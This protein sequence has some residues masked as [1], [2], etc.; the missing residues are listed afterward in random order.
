[1]K[2]TSDILNQ[3]CDIM[4]QMENVSAKGFKLGYCHYMAQK[5]SSESCTTKFVLNLMVVYQITTRIDMFQ[6]YFEVP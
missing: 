6:K 5:F 4:N 3:M 2:F 1:M